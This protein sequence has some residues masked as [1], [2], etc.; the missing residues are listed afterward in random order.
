MHQAFKAFRDIFGQEL[1]FWN[2]D[3]RSYDDIAR[4]IE[5]FVLMLLYTSASAHPHRTPCSMSITRFLFKL[6]TS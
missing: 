1:R 6:T 3:L 2:A 4:I 5:S